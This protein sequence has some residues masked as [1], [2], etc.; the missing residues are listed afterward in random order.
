MQKNLTT[1][2]QKIKEAS[3]NLTDVNNKHM[4]AIDTKKTI[5][6]LEIEIEKQQQYQKDQKKKYCYNTNRN[7]I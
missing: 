7:L 6:Q 1:C 5:E 3:E 2:E 4:K